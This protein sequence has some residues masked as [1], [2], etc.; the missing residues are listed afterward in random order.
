MQ[1]VS[2]PVSR[3][4]GGLPPR[5]QAAWASSSCARTT[6]SPA[7]RP[8][9]AGMTTY[10]RCPSLRTLRYRRG[11]LTVEISLILSY[12]GE[13]YITA[14]LVSACDAGA[15]RRSPA[16][17]SAARTGYQM[18]RALDRQADAIR[19]LVRELSPPDHS[20]PEGPVQ[21]AAHGEYAARPNACIRRL[22]ARLRWFFGHLPRRAGRVHPSAGR[23]HDTLRRHGRR[24]R[25]QY[26]AVC[27]CPY[28]HAARACQPDLH[29]GRLPL[30]DQ[31]R[32]LPRLTSRR[33]CARLWRSIL[34]PSA[35]DP[36]NPKPAGYSLSWRGLQ[37]R[38]SGAKPHERRD[39]ATAWVVRGQSP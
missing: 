20:G 5:R 26:P 10:T 37:Q 8:C 2:L 11:H 32:S 38:R 3:V 34:F 1:T 18:R 12:M 27:R 33:R 30:D 23:R 19:R 39:R 13:E 31:G 28:A 6:A 9:R 22:L 16:G 35:P 17:Q 29:P 24:A 25:P 21:S 4:P 14:A 15:V 36:V 7:L